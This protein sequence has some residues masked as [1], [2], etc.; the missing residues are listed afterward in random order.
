[1]KIL[2]TADL[3]MTKEN[4]N[5]IFCILRNRM[6]ECECGVLVIAGDICDDQ[7]I[8]PFST[9]MHFGYPV[10]FCLGNHEFAGKKPSDVIKKYSEYQWSWHKKQI[11]CLDV[12]D[13]VIIDDVQFVGNVLWYNGSICDTDNKLK[14]L[15]NISSAHKDS[16]VVDFDPIREHAKCVCK[17]KDALSFPLN[18]KVLVTHTVPHWKLNRFCVTEPTSEFNI[19]S[20]VKDLFHDNDI[21]VDV[22]IC[23]HTHRKE[24]FNYKKDGKDILCYN[25]GNGYYDE[26]NEIESETIEI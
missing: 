19:Y 21:D 24:S 20:G 23:G 11:Y 15:Y 26:T 13:E 17:I 3:H 14:K 9:F 22:A 5:D 4:C 16:S 8:D 1:M 6:Y 10:V 7:N 25:V 2:A 18:K 12:L